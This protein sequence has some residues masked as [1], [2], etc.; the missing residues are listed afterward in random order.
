MFNFISILIIMNMKLTGSLYFKMCGEVIPHQINGLYGGHNLECFRSKPIPFEACTLLLISRNCSALTYTVDGLCLLHDR[1]SLDWKVSAVESLLPNAQSLRFHKLI[2]HLDN[3]SGATAHPTAFSNFSECVL[4][5]KS[6]SS[7]AVNT[8]TLPRLGIIMSVTSDWVKAHTEEIEAVISNYNCY[9]RIHKYS[10]HL[11]IMPPMSPGRYWHHRHVIVTR[12]Y[13]PLFQYVLAVDADT[14]IS[15]MSQ[16]FEP[17]LSGPEHIFLH[18]REGGEVAASA[19]I[20]KNSFY[21]RCFMQFWSEIAPP[22]PL[23]LWPTNTGNI[24]EDRLGQWISSPNNDNGDLVFAVMTLVNV[25]AA[26]SCVAQVKNRKLKSLRYDLGMLRCFRVF[27]GALIDLRFIVP[28]LRV[29]FIREGFFRMHL[30]EV[31]SSYPL[32]DTACHRHD[33]L[34]HGWR[35]IGVHMWPGTDVERRTRCEF[36]MS[37]LGSGGNRQCKWLTRE[38]E[39][40]IVTHKCYW[41]SPICHT[42]KNDVG[43]IADHIW[44]TEVSSNLCL[45]NKL[46]DNEKRILQSWFICM[47]HGVCDPYVGLR[48]HARLANRTV[49]PYPWLGHSTT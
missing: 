22:Q 10:F 40:D 26:L 41:K 13:L 42:G 47:Q 34:L 16:S 8:N 24:T 19:Y 25:T 6:E 33:L 32:K 29:F 2:R 28:Q 43:Q 37:A 7:I 9:C 14:L 4:N 18:M 3:C 45:A 27:R 48:R 46:C 36:V 21:S 1:S 15:N 11:N 38:E 35:D 44:H 49:F 20:I 12:K 17:Y 30:G 31:G 39:L 5:K 23:L